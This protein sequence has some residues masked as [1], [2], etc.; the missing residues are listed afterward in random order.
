MTQNEPVEHV[1]FFRN[2]TSNPNFPINN[3]SNYFNY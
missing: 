1:L 2:L 3:I